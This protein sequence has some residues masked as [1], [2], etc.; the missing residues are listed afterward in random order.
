[1]FKRVALLF[2]LM[3]GDARTLWFAL[4]HPEAPAWLKVGVA[5]L[6]LYVLW[7][8]IP[9]IG[10]ID[11][12]IVVPLAIRFLLKRLPAEIAAQAAARAGR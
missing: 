2:N 4:R 11:D 9:V 6:V 12:M 10:L 3:R 5:L 7:P 1:M 8:G